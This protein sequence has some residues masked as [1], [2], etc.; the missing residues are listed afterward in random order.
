M[1]RLTGVSAG[2]DGEMDVNRSVRV[3]KSWCGGRETDR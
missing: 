1:G 3:Y 2:L